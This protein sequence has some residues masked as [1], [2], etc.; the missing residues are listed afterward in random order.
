MA[1]G[2]DS[3]SHTPGP[4]AL[5]GNLDRIIWRAELSGLLPWRSAPVIA[6]RMAAAIGRDLARGQL[7]LWAMSLVYT[8]LLSLVP[9]LAIG[10][11]VL[12]GFGVITRLS[13]CC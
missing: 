3:G 6:L 10:F 2:K 8:T 13:P 4:F 5:G 11:S 9:L 1:G 7:T 12:K